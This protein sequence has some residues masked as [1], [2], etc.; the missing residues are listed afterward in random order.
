MRDFV[1]VD[2][3]VGGD[4]HFPVETRVDILSATRPSTRA[5]AFDYLAAS[6]S[7][8]ISNPSRVPQSSSIMIEPLATSTRRRVQVARV[9]V[10]RR[11]IGETLCVRRVSDE[12]TGNT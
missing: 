1:L 8:A 10:V 5:E 4:Q 3:Y 12:S 9:A 2:I 7:G 6:T 11:G